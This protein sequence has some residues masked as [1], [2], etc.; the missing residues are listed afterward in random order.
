MELSSLTS[1][2]IVF[3]VV[4]LIVIVIAIAIIVSI[5]E[6]KKMVAVATK[7][8]DVKLPFT[9]RF[10]AKNTVTATKQIFETDMGKILFTTDTQDC[11]NSKDDIILLLTDGP[12]NTAAAA[13]ASN[14][15]ISNKTTHDITVSAHG[16][17]LEIASSGSV[18]PTDPFNASVAPLKV[19]ADTEVEG[20]IV[21]NAAFAKVGSFT[22][23]FEFSNTVFKKG[24]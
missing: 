1:T 17:L 24:S 13:C 9:L 2:N 5:Y 15:K 23:T 7:N 22:V 14:V 11:K 6:K 16:P 21:V 3:L 8:I 18:T 19:P 4:I 20:I 12:V 10:T